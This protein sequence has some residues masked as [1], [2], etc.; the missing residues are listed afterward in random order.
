MHIISSR[1]H[2]FNILMSLKK[3]AKKFSFDLYEFFY[4]SSKDL[5][6]S[7]SNGRFLIIYFKVLLEVLKISFKFFFFIGASAIKSWEMS[8]IFRYGLP[9][10]VLSKRQYSKWS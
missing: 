8:R 3:L 5:L 2:V 4:M 9:E 1:S 10:D 6:N 7:F